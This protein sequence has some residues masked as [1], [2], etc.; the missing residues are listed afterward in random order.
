MLLGLLLVRLTGIAWL[1]PIAAIVV[2]L[3]LARTGVK[4]VRESVGALLDQEDPALL[5]R[6]VEAF[7]EAPQRGI[8]GIHRLRAIRS[9]ISSTRMRMSS[10]PSTGPCARRTPRWRSSRAS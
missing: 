2:G 9:A 6:L 1:D 4:L 3:L 8:S 5:E 7:N 10:C